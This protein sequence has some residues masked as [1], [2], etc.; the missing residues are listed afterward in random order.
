MG[1]VAV[2]MIV[3]CHYIRMGSDNIYTNNCITFLQ[4]A[5]NTTEIITIYEQY[6][7][8]SCCKIGRLFTK[9]I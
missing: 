6:P 2:F 4:F 7:K 8:L 3:T 1:R 9:L 5:Y